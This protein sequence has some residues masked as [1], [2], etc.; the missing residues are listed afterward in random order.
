MTWWIS[1]VFNFYKCDEKGLL[2]SKGWIGSGTYP[3]FKSVILKQLVASSP[4]FPL[5]T[6][7]DMNGESIGE[8]RFKATSGDILTCKSPLKG[9]GK[10]E[11][12]LSKGTGYIKLP[13][14]WH[15]TQKCHLH[16]TSF[17]VL[18]QPLSM[19]FQKNPSP[20]SSP[21]ETK[22]FQ[23]ELLS[24][25]SNS[26]PLSK[27][28]FYTATLYLK[29]VPEFPVVAQWKRI[30]LASMRMQVRSLASLSGLRIQCCCELRCRL[31]TWLGSSIAAAVA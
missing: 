27:A 4:T 19:T 12:R 16:D 25:K 5:R 13:G 29:A 31:K 23:K 15:G 1:V 11:M 10:N 3:D 30:W 2:S 17:P 18:W 28:N 21:T 9:K 20:S 26:H 6:T 24:L 8:I 14:N 22:T 7:L